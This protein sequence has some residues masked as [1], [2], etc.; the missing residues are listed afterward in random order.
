MSTEEKIIE[1]TL[2]KYD[3]MKEILEEGE[4]SLA[5]NPK[6]LGN[7]KDKTFVDFQRMKVV[8]KNKSTMLNLVESL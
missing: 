6:F 5:K 2:S 3:I 1:A 4:E 8:Y 7:E